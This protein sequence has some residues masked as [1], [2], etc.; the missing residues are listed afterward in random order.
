M[1]PDGTHRRERVEPDD[2]ESVRARRAEARRRWS[3]RQARHVEVL[4]RAQETLWTAQTQLERSEETLRRCQA[5]LDR[6]RRQAP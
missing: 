3:V 6:A 4:G 1:D 2:W 5:S